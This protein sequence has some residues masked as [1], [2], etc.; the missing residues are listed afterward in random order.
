MWFG[1]ASL[2]AARFDGETLSWHYEEQLQTTPRGG[3]FG[4][5]A[6]FEDND[7]RF[8][9]NNTRFRYTVTPNRTSSLDIRKDDG[10]GFLNDDHQTE[11]PFFL[12]MTQDQDGNLWMATYDTG[13]WKYDGRGLTQYP[14]KDGIT[15]VLLFTIYTDNNGVL[16]L[17][18]HNAGAY[19]FN[20]R[21][22]E[23]FVN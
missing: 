10:I 1:T 13:V 2:G 11:F 21:S 5:R 16:W 17:G 18:S 9:I 14:V 12:S 20:G 19:R 7:G 6:I 8:W 3:D 4:T 22:F 23:R 15:D